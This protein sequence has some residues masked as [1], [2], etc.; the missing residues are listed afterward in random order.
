MNKQCKTCKR[1]NMY[2]MI[3][4][5]DCTP[6]DEIAEDEGIC[7]A[8]DPRLATVDEYLGHAEKEALRDNRKDVIKALKKTRRS[9]KL[10]LIGKVMQQII[11]NEIIKSNFTVDKLNKETED[12]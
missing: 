2:D 8:Y 1:A 7:H 10:P 11:Q 3:C 12:E 9:L 5:A 6:L 4:G